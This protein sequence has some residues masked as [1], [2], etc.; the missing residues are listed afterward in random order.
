MS[1]T[2][3]FSV[4]AR[5]TRPS[6]RVQRL[7]SPS[8][9]PLILLGNTRSR[10]PISFCAWRGVSSRVLH[11]AWLAP[12]SFYLAAGGRMCLFTRFAACFLPCRERRART[13]V[14][15]SFF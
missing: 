9:T 5:P 11:E 8:D 13:P 10:D 15:H 2:G 4:G 6:G 12:F 3:A 7:L 1:D 14:L